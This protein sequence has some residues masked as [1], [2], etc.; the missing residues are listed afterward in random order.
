MGL[1]R[2]CSAAEM[3]QYQNQVHLNKHKIRK[4]GAGVRDQDSS[5]EEWG[6]EEAEW[7]ES[8]QARKQ[9]EQRIAERRENVDNTIIAGKGFSFLFK[10]IHAQIWQVI[11]AYIA[12][13]EV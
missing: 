9:R 3:R 13:L 8:E 7:G 10:S 12:G 1:M 6:N 2:R 4:H 11:M 5:E